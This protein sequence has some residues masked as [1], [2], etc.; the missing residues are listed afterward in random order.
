MIIDYT[1][2]RTKRKS[3]A[4]TV[5]CGKVNVNAPLKSSK[6]LIEQFVFSKSNWIQSAIDKYNTQMQKFEPLINQHYV[7]LN[8]EYI[9]IDFENNINTKFKDGVLLV[10]RKYFGKK[11]LI[12]GQIAK[13]YKKIAQNSLIPR[14]ELIAKEFGIKFESIQLT[15]AKKKWGSCDSKGR[16]K[17]NY[18]LIM[19]R[20][21]LQD[22]VIIHELCHT[23]E[24]NHS[25]KFWA[26]VGKYETNYKQ[27][28]KELKSY[29]LLNTLY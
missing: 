12:F 1:L 22:Y 27:L 2:K 8:G 20:Q 9:E 23:I 6:E 28:R 17:L 24:H 3:I 4:I 10:N 13:L 21:E 18:R 7:L 11:E 19:L 29:S 25:N 26:Q 5:I 15:S 16:I 14:C